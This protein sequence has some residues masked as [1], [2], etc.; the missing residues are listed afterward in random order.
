MF[1]DA[2]REMAQGR[3]ANKSDSP[4]NCLVASLCFPQ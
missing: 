4:C 2:K 3:V 1:Y